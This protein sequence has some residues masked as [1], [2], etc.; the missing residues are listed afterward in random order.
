[1]GVHMLIIGG[2]VCLCHCYGKVCNWGFDVG[3]AK[4]HSSCVYLMY[5]VYLN[6]RV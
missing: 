5:W 6:F 3:G 4:I 2:V 1:M